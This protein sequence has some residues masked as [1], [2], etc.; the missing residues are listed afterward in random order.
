[1]SSARALVQ[2]RRA[3]SLT[4]PPAQIAGVSR[5]FSEV[6]EEENG[7]QGSSMDPSFGVIPGPLFSTQ[8]P[9]Q[10]PNEQALLVRLQALKRQRTL[11]ADSQREYEQFEKALTPHEGL[12]FVLLTMLETRDLLR[13]LTLAQEYR[14][15][16]TVKTTCKD[17][18]CIFLLSPALLQYKL[19]KNAAPNV[20]MAMRELG[21]QN[22]PDACETGRCELILEIIKK[23]MTDFRH[24]LKE[25]IAASIKSNQDIAALTKACIGTSKAKPTAGLFIRIAF[26]RW[27]YTTNPK[28]TGDTFWKIVDEHLIKTRREY[29]TTAEQQEVFVALYEADLARFGQPDLVNHPQVSVNDI[30]S[31]ILQVNAAASRVHV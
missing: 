4:N 26:L 3:A 20:L 11:S 25:K 27:M 8:L 31:W 24:H 10:I 7:F 6:Q 30:D 18:A 29:P 9:G 1:M 2:A 12:A 13:L 23:A 17:Y 28:A 19:D 22:L 21:I 14:A 15:P 16:D 5:L